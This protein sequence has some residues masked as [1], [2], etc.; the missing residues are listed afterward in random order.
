MKSKL[1]LTILLFLF[2]IANINA[3]SDSA[4]FKFTG[5]QVKTMRLITFERDF[6]KV[7][8]DSLNKRIGYY[9]LL[10]LNNDLIISMQDTIINNKEKQI[11]DLEK[12]PLNVTQ[13]RPYSTLEI[14]GYSFIVSALSFIA[15]IFVLK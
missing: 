8:N 13:I 2:I 10:A 15:G 14:I 6:L 11:V 5:K 7:E 12:R 1:L 3:Q 4:I 9:K